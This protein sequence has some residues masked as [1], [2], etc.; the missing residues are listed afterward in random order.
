ME[1]KYKKKQ[2]KKTMRTKAYV[3]THPLHWTG[4]KSA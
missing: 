2:Q 3:R 4:N 1:I